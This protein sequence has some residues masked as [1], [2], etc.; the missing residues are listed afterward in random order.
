MSENESIWARMTAILAV[1][2]IVVLF[3]LSVVAELRDQLKEEAVKRGF[4]EWIVIGENNTEFK[5]KVKQ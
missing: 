3:I 1:V 2:L 5:W 4:A